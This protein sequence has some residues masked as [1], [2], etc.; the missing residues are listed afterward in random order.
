LSVSFSGSIHKHFS[1]KRFNWPFCKNYY[2]L[3]LKP[4]I[5][6]RGKKIK[7]TKGKTLTLKQQLA[8][9]AKKRE[10]LL[11]EIQ[12]ALQKEVRV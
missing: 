1:I 4:D 5:S 10:K 3:C 12:K 6:Y 8:A 7:R 11:K 9:E 2:S